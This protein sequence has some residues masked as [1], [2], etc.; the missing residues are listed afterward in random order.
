MLA[1]MLAPAHVRDIFLGFDTDRLGGRSSAAGGSSEQS[2]LRNGHKL[3]LALWL[4][5]K[6]AGLGLRG[7]VSMCERALLLPQLHIP[8]NVSAG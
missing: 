3:C 8:N 7:R 4:S 6:R 1:L 5:G 2:P